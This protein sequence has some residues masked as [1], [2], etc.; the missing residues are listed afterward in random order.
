MGFKNT[1]PVL[2][3]YIFVIFQV[4]IPSDDVQVMLEE[5]RILSRNITLGSNEYILNYPPKHMADIKRA[6][7]ES[8]FSV[9]S[10][11]YYLLE[12]NIATVTRQK[13]P[14]WVISIELHFCFLFASI[15]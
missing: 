11:D 4:H 15:Y 13:D 7:A 9:C 8:T 2:C 6:A 12:A 10:N 14:L 5:I 3:L 1:R